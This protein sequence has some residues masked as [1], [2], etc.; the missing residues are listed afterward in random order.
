[1]AELADALA[2]GASDSNI[3]E[4][5]VLLTASVLQ[6]WL[7]IAQAITGHFDF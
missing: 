6:I 1:M 5:R 3:V 2:S 7:V 4:V